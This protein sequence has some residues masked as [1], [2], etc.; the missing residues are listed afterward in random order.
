MTDT[1]TTVTAHQPEPWYWEAGSDKCPH[2]EKPNPAASDEEHET[3][4]YRHRITDDAVICLDAPMGDMC[5]ACSED[6]GDAVAF[7]VCRARPHVQARPGAP[8]DTGAHEP[9][10][11]FVGL[12]DHLDRDCDELYTDGGDEITDKAHCSHVSQQV[13]CGGCSVLVHGYYE[14]AVPWSGPHTAPASSA[15]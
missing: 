2:G 11:V 6:H 12:Y 3:W 8:A 1:A 10:I 4:W 5:G 14:P 13:I 9:V 15:A 7:T